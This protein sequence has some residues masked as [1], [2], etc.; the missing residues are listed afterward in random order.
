MQTR[1]HQTSLFVAPPHE[2]AQVTDSAGVSR[3][4]LPLMAFREGSVQR[5][6]S[7]DNG[8]LM[9]SSIPDEI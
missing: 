2:D 1:I 5:S 7:A 4:H 8:T 3:S 6:E 9:S